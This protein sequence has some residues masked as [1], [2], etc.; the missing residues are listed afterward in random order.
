[1][2]QS[3]TFEPGTSLPLVIEP[4]SRKIDLLSW[5][6]DNCDYLERKLLIHGG[7]LLRGFNVKTASEFEAFIKTVSAQALEYRERSSPRSLVS[8]H[9]YTSTDHPA[10]QSIFLHNENSYQQV[11]NMKIF[12]FC[13]VPAA[14]GGE[15][16]I[17]DCRKIFDRIDPQV[18]EKF[19]EKKWM[20]IRNYGDG[21][22][23]PWQTVFQTNDKAVVER[24][25]RENGI[26][27]EW[28]DGDRLSTRATLSAILKHPKTGEM[29]W[30]NHA[31][32][33]HVSTLPTWVY[34]AL[35]VE[36]DDESDLP[37]NTYYGDGST[38]TPSVLHHL[39]EVYNQE[40]ISYPWRKG[41]VL[42]LDNML[43]AHGRAP[44]TGERKILVGMAEPV[45][46]NDLEP[47]ASCP[48]GCGQD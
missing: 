47:G 26:C 18:R 40:M 39:R 34:E 9:I 1:M 32:F 25:C 2:I 24:H 17:A 11:I 20:Y 22:G 14:K 44:Y 4:S 38:I 37:T 30:F 7:V 35:M 23:L 5:A 36:F 13:Q 12:F 29:V 43:I 42:M 27:V 15:T 8:G 33:F 16:P 19:A 6:A 48:T 46:R 31:T 45:N 10:D 28:K 21:F 3:Y 41:D